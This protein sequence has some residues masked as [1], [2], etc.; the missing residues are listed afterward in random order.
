MQ[1]EGL[2]CPACN[3]NVKLS[4]TI[5]DEE[6]SDWIFCSCGSVFHQ[7]KL[8]PD[9]WEK[10][11]LPNY[12]GWKAIKDRYEYIEKVYIPIVEELTYGRKF[13][14]IGFGTDYHIRNLRERGWFT[15]GIDL[16]KS[17][18]L[19]GDFETYKFDEKYDLIKL[20]NVIG[21]FQEPLKALY[22]IKELL[23]PSGLVLILAPDAELIYQKGM[24]SWG[25]WNW[26]E[27]WIVFSEKQML[28]ILDAMG[29]DVILRHKNTEKRFMGWNFY[30][31][32]AQRRD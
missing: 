14:D 20:G 32:L 19:V 12:R 5:A 1:I 15:Q 2:K 11:Y 17:E 18:Y 22:K 7:K 27:N 28:K 9:Y 23:N 10:E 31:I 13:L 3:S 21:A 30:H 8:D 26:K 24:F 16:F 4:F 25:N 6:K 29:F